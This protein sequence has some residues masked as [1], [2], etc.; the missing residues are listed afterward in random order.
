MA[1]HGVFA[2]AQARKQGSQRNQSVNVLDVDMFY[3][4]MMQVV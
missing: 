4:D 1:N 2:L 3:V